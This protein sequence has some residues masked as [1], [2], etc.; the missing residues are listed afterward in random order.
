M[1]FVEQGHTSNR[2]QET[3]CGTGRNW[4]THPVPG[5][6]AIRRFGPNLSVAHV[7]GVPGRQNINIMVASCYILLL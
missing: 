5:V 6:V 1:S 2:S 7:L 3:R 4:Q